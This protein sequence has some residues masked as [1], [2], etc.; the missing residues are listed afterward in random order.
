M[1]LNFFLILLYSEM[2]IIFI[3][4][5]E[6]LPEREFL[7]KFWRHHHVTWTAE[8]PVSG[9]A[10]GRGCLS[11]PRG[12]CRSSSPLTPACAVTSWPEDH[13][14][15]GQ[16][17]GSAWWGCRSQCGPGG[18]DRGRGTE[19][20]RDL[21]RCWG[22]AAA[23]TWA[24]A[25]WRPPASCEAACALQRSGYWGC[26]GCGGCGQPASSGRLRGWLRSPG[27]GS[28]WRLSDERWP[29]SWK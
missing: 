25:A 9:A 8:A 13:W 3:E 11:G 7:S 26:S 1:H 22:R 6:T 23:E 14:R 2:E 16:R 4:K 5:I 19:W 28:G 29:R 24:A 12:R 27:T 20:G 15:P 18:C 10:P 17:L 21:R